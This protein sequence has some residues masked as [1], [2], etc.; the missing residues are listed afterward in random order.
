MVS[1][2]FHVSTKRN[3]YSFLRKESSTT[4]QKL[5]RSNMF[6]FMKVFLRRAENILA[7]INYYFLF[8]FKF[9]QSNNVNLYETCCSGDTNKVLKYIKRADININFLHPEYVNKLVCNW[10]KT[11]LFTIILLSGRMYYVIYG[12]SSKLC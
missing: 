2:G 5:H 9:K 11:I 8:L 12:I 4:S 6:S 10:A 7:L 1:Y 3:F